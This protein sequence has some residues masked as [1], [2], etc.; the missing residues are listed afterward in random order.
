[1][2][3]NATSE[4]LPHGYA[5]PVSRLLDMEADDLLRPEKWPNYAARF[6]FS[7]E[8]IPALIQMA[9]DMSLHNGGGMTHEVW[10]PVHAWRALAQFRAVEAVAPLLE[11]YPEIADSEAPYEELCDVFHMI[12][13]AAVPALSA[14]LATGT[15]RSSP[16]CILMDG[17]VKIGMGYPGHRDACIAAI[18]YVLDRADNNDPETNGWAISTLMDLKAIEAIDTIREAFRL[19]AVDH[20]IAGDL[21]DVEIGLGLRTRRSTPAKKLHFTWGSR[22]AEEIEITRDM[23]EEEVRAPKI[24]RNEP[25]PCG[26]GKKYKKCCL[27]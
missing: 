7:P 13:P 26:S 2:S 19:D 20:S 17:L 18:T 27:V 21:E 24:G 5:D 12:G 8:H 15:L 1:M 9:C 23:V 6:G 3:E 16:A 10:A 4:E 25:C 22:P 11:S 14:A